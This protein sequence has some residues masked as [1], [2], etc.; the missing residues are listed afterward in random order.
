MSASSTGFTRGYSG[1]PLE[2]T[3][4]VVGHSAGLKVI[5]PQARSLKVMSSSGMRRRHTG[6]RPSAR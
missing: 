1:S 6:L 3:T 2:R 4:H 5:S